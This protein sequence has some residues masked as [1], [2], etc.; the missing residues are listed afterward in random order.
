MA[1]SP[2]PSPVERIPPDVYGA[3]DNGDG[4]WWVSSGTRGQAR[5]Y[6]ANWVGAD[7]VRLRA[8]RVHLRAMTEE[9]KVAEYGSRAGSYGVCVTECPPED[10]RAVPGWRVEEVSHV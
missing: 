2:S 4:P 8:Y 5:A 3:D 6:V 9:E 7:F 1:D 10:S